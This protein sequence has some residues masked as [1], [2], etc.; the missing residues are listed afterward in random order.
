MG[1]EYGDQ[2]AKPNPGEP[3]DNSTGV[4]F[5]MYVTDLL[6]MKLTDGSEAYCSVPG[7]TT[8]GY[9][10]EPKTEPRFACGMLTW[11][12]LSSWKFAWQRDGQGGFTATLISPD[13][14]AVL[15]CDQDGEGATRE[16]STAFPNAYVCTLY[17]PASGQRVGSA[18][19][20]VVGCAIDGTPIR[21]LGAVKAGRPFWGGGG[22]AAEGAV[23]YVLLAGNRQLAEVPVTNGVYAMRV[24]LPKGVSEAS[25]VR[26]YNAAGQV[27]DTYMP[28]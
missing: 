26:A 6:R 10:G 4:Q 23:R 14:K 21:S 11:L 13:R 22:V 9:E 2:G 1:A 18:P 15:L 27:V 28:F 20:G 12:E 16:K 5:G 3:I 17:G 8:P 19:N 7:T 24:W 25:E